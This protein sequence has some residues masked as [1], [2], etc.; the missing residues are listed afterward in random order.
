MNEKF[1]RKVSEFRD[2]LFKFFNMEKISIKKIYTEIEA[3]DK[4]PTDK[5]V[6]FIFEFSNS[7][8]VSISLEKL[9]SLIK[10]AEIWSSQ[11]NDA[12]IICW[13]FP[14]NNPKR[15][16]SYIYPKQL[17][18]SYGEL[19]N[20]SIVWSWR[21]QENW[22]DKIAQL[23]TGDIPFA[24]LEE[25]MKDLTKKEFLL[26]QVPHHGSGD[27]NYWDPKIL[28][29]KSYYWIISAG[30]QNTYG[31]PSLEVIDSIL[32]K[33]KLP[34]WVNETNNFQAQAIVEW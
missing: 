6:K 23:Y 1:N 4:K 22:L 3:K 18:L 34:I 8:S 20:N 13:H 9:K 29:L 28:A 10:E 26:L 5:N 7:T 30:I 12:S 19:K 25:V 24:L 33:G 27:R 11:R 31:H 2:I 15:V 17:S 16:M 14:I 32:K 21:C